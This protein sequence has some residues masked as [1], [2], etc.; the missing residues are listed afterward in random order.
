MAS[1]EKP[2]LKYFLYFSSFTLLLIVVALIT[3]LLVTKNTNSVSILP[4]LTE[5]PGSSSTGNSGGTGDHTGLACTP[6]SSNFKFQTCKSFAD[7]AQC[8]AGTT[9]E[10]ATNGITSTELDAQ[11]KLVTPGHVL[12]ANANANAHDQC[13]RLPPNCTCVNNS[14]DCVNDQPGSF[15]VPKH[16]TLCTSATSLSVLAS[17]TGDDNGQ[18]I[19][20]CRPEYRGMFTQAVES[21]ECTLP[22]ICN[23]DSPQRDPDGAVQQ[24]RTFSHMDADGNPVFESKPVYTN[25]ITTY[26][27]FLT[28]D[29]V[30]PTSRV[31]QGE[32]L[33]VAADADPTCTPEMV[34]NRCDTT[35]FVYST[36]GY[37]ADKPLNV[38]VRGSGAPGDPLLSRV[39]PAYFAPVP[40]AL[41]RCPTGFTGMNSPD[42][43]CRRGNDTIEFRPAAT[44]N[45]DS[46]A[47]RDPNDTGTGI[48]YSSV[49]DT[50]GEWSGNFACL[51]DLLTATYRINSGEAATVS[52]LNWDSLNTGQ[53][54]NE[55]RC[56]KNNWRVR[57]IVNAN[58][59]V[60]NGN[61][62][63]AEACVGTAC[64]G[65]RGKRPLA[66]DGFRDGPLE[67]SEGLPW[68]VTGA[69]PT[70]GGQC[71]CRGTQQ[72]G[73]DT[74]PLLANSSLVSLMDH[75]DTAD[76]SDMALWH[77]RQDSCWSSSHPEDRFD[78]ARGTCACGIPL[79]SSVTQ[80][81]NSKSNSSSSSWS[82]R[83]P[84]AEADGAPTCIADSCNPHGVG[85]HTRVPCEVSD[86]CTGICYAKK[87][88]FP[89]GGPTDSLCNADS[90]CTDYE[91]DAG[92]PG[93]CV[94]PKEI[95]HSGEHKICIY[96]DP[97]R[98]RTG[99]VCETNTQCSYGTCVDRKPNA[100]GT[101][102]IGFCS[103]GCACNPDSLQVSD[104]TG[105]QGATC[106][107]QC[108]LRPCLNG[109]VCTV[110]PA[111]VA[112]C[113]CPNAY[114][115]NQCEIVKDC[116]QAGETPCL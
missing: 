68:F 93:R 74:V 112:S 108:T 115:G 81:S 73:S 39:S 116:T 87:C 27:P 43:P 16:G 63:N 106:Q 51:G 76:N 80:N 60:N 102:V 57:P 85:T 40:L 61:T 71:D 92:V 67:N 44:V 103:G 53:R 104:N 11:G 50:D 56:E 18:F 28:E 8:E 91:N 114:R 9:F 38:T 84:F 20:E 10:C 46:E 99:T 13:D 22:L 98:A 7:C 1:S 90:D 12:Y 75:P 89:Y 111:G 26:N 34:T 105:P 42:A 62:I 52:N 45:C 72:R 96:E 24:Y 86:E 94:D 47:T 109:G 59:S 101:M 69:G 54:V 49:F 88:H 29:C 21:G 78:A 3:V 15:C 107:L 66:W 82:S 6:L 113:A 70:F 97:E 110:T 100:S 2:K 58:N 5:T 19:C 37:N 83:V 36:G 65:V 31:K 23:A 77:C 17:A 41:K 95:G 4:P 55:V 30:V 33:H 64:S 14:I 79:Q 25:R 32:D 48:W 35:L